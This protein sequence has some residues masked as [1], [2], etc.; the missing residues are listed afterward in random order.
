MITRLVRIG[1]SQ[2]IRIPKSLLEQA[3]LHDEVDVH[4]EDGSLVIRRARKPREGWAQAFREMAQRGDDSLL[5]DVSLTLSS[6]DKDE[7]EW[8]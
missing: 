4:V 7:W 8:R 1:N 2:G 6:W 3:G 5:D